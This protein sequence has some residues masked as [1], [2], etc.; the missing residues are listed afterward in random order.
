MAVFRSVVD[1][2]LS[3]FGDLPP[4]LLR[5]HPA[6]AYDPHVEEEVDSVIAWHFK[7]TPVM[8]P[9]HSTDAGEKGQI[10]TFTST[11][12]REGARAPLPAAKEGSWGSRSRAALAMARYVLRCNAISPTAIPD[13]ARLPGERPDS[14]RP[15]RPKPSP[16]SASRGDRAAHITGQIIGGATGGEVYQPSPRWRRY[17]RRAY[18][19][20]LA[21]YGRA[22]GGPLRPSTLFISRAAAATG[23][24]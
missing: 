9:P 13:D 23:G 12:G 1:L 6:R 16:P 14:P 3:A 22:P 24:A 5:G 10:V 18:P 17:H 4:R 11:A 8:R 19:R 2:A 15:R 21:E 20:R 7:G